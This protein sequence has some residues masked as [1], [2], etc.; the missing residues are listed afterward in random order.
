MN[1]PTLCPAM[2][3]A[4]I[5]RISFFSRGEGEGN[6]FMS[7]GCALC[8][9][10]SLWLLLRLFFCASTTP[11]LEPLAPLFLAFSCSTVRFGS[12]SGCGTGVEEGGRVEVILEGEDG[13]GEGVWITLG[14]WG[15]VGDRA[16][17]VATGLGDGGR[18]GVGGATGCGDVGCAGS[19]V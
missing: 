4:F 6:A 1:A 11:M 3:M 19:A 5:L 7:V 9:E 8:L 2:V 15:G 14:D 12:G 17:A 16:A 10:E 18:C 13:G